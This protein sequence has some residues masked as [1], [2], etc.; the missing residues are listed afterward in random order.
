MKRRIE[1]VTY[2]SYMDSPLG[3]LMLVSDGRSLTGLYMMGH[4]GAHGPGSSWLHQDEAAPF[5]EAR[6]QLAEYFAGLRKQFDL[7]LDMEG[8]DFQREVWWA[9][10]EIPFGETISY[11]ELARRVGRPQGAQAVGAANGR[12]PISIIVPCHRVIGADGSLVGYGG[13]LPR[14]EL[15]LRLEGWNRE[16]HTVGRQLVMEGLTLAA[17]APVAIGGEPRQ[18][19][20]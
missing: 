18:E 16:D 15:L 8:T 7:P 5:A 6:Q 3:T 12:N 10:R 11:G 20:I 17:T 4:E 9:L 1:M 2:Y 19:S 13:G 14:K